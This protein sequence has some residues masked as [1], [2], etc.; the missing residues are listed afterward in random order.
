MLK[1]K[2]LKAGVDHHKRVSRDGLLGE[3]DSLFDLSLAA[4][5]RNADLN[6]PK[7]FSGIPLPAFKAIGSGGAVV[8]ESIHHNPYVCIRSSATVVVTPAARPQRSVPRA[9]WA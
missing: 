4:R 7:A 5:L 8:F 1:L 6:R 3:R 2:G 9:G